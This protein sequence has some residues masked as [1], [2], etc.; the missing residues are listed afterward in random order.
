MD[1]DHKNLSESS[2]SEA[3]TN[4][5][6]RDATRVFGRIRKVSMNTARSLGLGNED[7]EDI[8]METLEKYLHQKVKPDN[9]E[10]WATTVARNLSID[11]LR[12]NNRQ[13]PQEDT[14]GREL[15]DFLRR[16]AST[17]QA[18]ISNVLDQ[19]IWTGLRAELSEK[20]LLLLEMVNQ[21]HSYEQIA[22]KL[23]YKNAD[24]VKAT[25]V[26]LRSK[27]QGALIVDKQDLLGHPRNY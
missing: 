17:S 12:K 23:G 4:L 26:R 7:Q 13:I 16:G 25:V 27:A 5:D 10:A 8:H 9:V 14:E 18:A 3:R 21:G 6:S 2:L 11:L 22:E 24:T 1:S 20:D 15:V 19:D